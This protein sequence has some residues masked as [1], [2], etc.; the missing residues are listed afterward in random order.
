[1]AEKD[2][3]ETLRKIRTGVVVTARLLELGRAK[4]VKKYGEMQKFAGKYQF[5]TTS[6]LLGLEEF[7]RARKRRR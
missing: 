5:P 3:R 1:L 7:K 4:A 2:K 6:Q